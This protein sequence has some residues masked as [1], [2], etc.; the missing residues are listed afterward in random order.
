MRTGVTNDLQTF[1]VFRS[2]NGELRIVFNEIGSINQFAVHAAGNGGFRQTWT[3][4]QGNIHW[5]YSVVEM[6][7]ATIRKS[8]N[9][10]FM[11]LFAVMP[12]T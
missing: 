1:F 11:S 12:H 5:A 6:A 10:H 3:D 2:N 4:V 7:L 9:R 8:N